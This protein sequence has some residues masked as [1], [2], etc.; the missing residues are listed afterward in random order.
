MS[1]APF[2]SGP[3]KPPKRHIAPPLPDRRDRMKTDPTG[4]GGKHISGADDRAF[5]FMQVV[6]LCTIAMIWVVVIVYFAL[7]PT[8]E[9]FNETV[10]GIIVAG[11]AGSGFG[12]KLVYNVGS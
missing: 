9:A 7:R 3:V 6:W 12:F 10:L 8:V 2:Q 1:G 11:I 4:S 5:R